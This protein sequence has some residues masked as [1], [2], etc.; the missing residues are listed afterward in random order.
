[1]NDFFCDVDEGK[2]ISEEERKKVNEKENVKIYMR[3]QHERALF[4]RHQL[5][6]FPSCNVP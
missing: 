5:K 4:L 1:M 2:S 3:I 6:S